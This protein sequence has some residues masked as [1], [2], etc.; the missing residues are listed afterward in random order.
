[1]LVHR[2]GP[3]SIGINVAPSLQTVGLYNHVMFWI[4]NYLEPFCRP[5]DL[6]STAF[7]SFVILEYNDSM[8]RYLKKGDN[9]IRGLLL[10]ESPML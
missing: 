2:P 1:M 10:R 9:R 8:Y 5:N 4:H 7:S 3:A 6:C